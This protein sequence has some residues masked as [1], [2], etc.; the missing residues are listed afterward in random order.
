MLTEE[1]E[2]SAPASIFEMGIRKEI[3]LA[4]PFARYRQCELESRGED[5]V[6]QMLLIDAMVILTDIFLEK[7]DRAT[8]AA[9][10]EVRVPFFGQ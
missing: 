6:N 10:I 3:I 9:S 1:D 5:V 7:V 8:M 2:Q 4:D